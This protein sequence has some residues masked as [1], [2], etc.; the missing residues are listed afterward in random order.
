M[1]DEPITSDLSLPS[2]LTVGELALSVWRVYQLAGGVD[3]AAVGDEGPSDPSDAAGWAEAVRWAVAFWRSSLGADG[4][5]PVGPLVEAMYGAYQL[6]R[7]EPSY[8]PLGLIPTAERAAW[9]AAVRHAFGSIECDPAEVR[10]LGEH[11]LF[12]RDWA[13]THRATLTGAA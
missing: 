5:V 8:L 13:A 4:E 11:E 6:G 3:P 10:H 9:S 2:G 1:R 7:G 12:W